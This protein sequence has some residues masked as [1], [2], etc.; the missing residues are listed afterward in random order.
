MLDI[1][2]HRDLETSGAH[3]IEERRNRAVAM[4][5]CLEPLIAVTEHHIERDIPA[6]VALCARRQKLEP[7]PAGVRLVGR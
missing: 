2:I 4:T 7:T 3:D 5:G 6:H 1:V